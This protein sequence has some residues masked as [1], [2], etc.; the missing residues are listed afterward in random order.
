MKGRDLIPPILISTLGRMRSGSGKKQYATYHEALADCSL[1]G[2]ENHDLVEVVVSKT[3]RYREQLLQ[4]SKPAPVDATSATSLF[5]LLLS[6]EAKGE[7]N[8]ID[9]GGAAGAHYFLARSLL[10]TTT[11]LNWRVVETPAMVK[12]ATLKLAGN[13]LQFHSNL[14]EA[15]GSM[16]AVDL[17]HTCGTLQCV[18]NPYAELKQLV[19]IQAK[20]MLLNRLGVTKGDHDVIT[21]HQSR[22]SWNGP[23]PLP[24]GMT[25]HTIAYPFVFPQESLLRGIIQETYREIA[26]FDDPSGIF[27]VRGE[28]IVGIGLL[29]ARLAG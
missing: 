27:P 10:S 2:Y 26:C 22:L 9:F 16:G 1:N 19:R 6:A 24:A 14:G 25:D 7:I 20:Y 23:G 11:R 4:A 3:L 12:Q 21:I 15:K 8:V 18:A 5:A 13:E 28:P 17:L 29:A